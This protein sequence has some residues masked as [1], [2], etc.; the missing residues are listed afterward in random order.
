MANFGAADPVQFVKLRIGG[1][2]PQSRPARSQSDG[3]A[4]RF[5]AGSPRA[6]AFLQINRT[7]VNGRLV[8]LPA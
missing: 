5:S 8:E 7:F 2:V 4:G 3:L 6:G 1:P